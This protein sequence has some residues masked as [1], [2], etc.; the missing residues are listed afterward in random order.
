MSGPEQVATGV[1]LDPDRIETVEL[2]LDLSQAMTANLCAAAREHGLTPP[3]ARAV[4]GLGAP[5]PMR[6]LANHLSCD[7]SHV[8]GLVDGLERLGLVDRQPDPRDRRVRHLV[9]TP[10]GQRVRD[11]LRVRLYVDA[12][13]V[14]NLTPTEEEQ[15]RALLRRALQ[16]TD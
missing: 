11:Q 7:K 9:L 8:T 13:A 6:D 2:I 5:A 12:P 1:Q 3:Q 14:G 10:A 4:L 16:P 15:L